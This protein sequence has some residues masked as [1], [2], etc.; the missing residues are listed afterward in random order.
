MLFESRVPLH[1]SSAGASTCCVNAAVANKSFTCDRVAV[2]ECLYLMYSVAGCGGEDV[3][4]ARLVCNKL[5]H[6]SVPAGS[7][8]N[9]L[10][11]VLSPA[12]NRVDRLLL[13][14]NR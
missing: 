14:C 9:K 3:A 10:H 7:R 2:I 4:H 13:T 12:A 5:L 6:V 11:G 8:A 1:L